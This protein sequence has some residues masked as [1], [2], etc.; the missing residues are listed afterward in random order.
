MESRMET[1][2]NV[3][4]SE[5]MNTGIANGFHEKVANEYASAD[6]L[7]ETITDEL[8]KSMQEMKENVLEQVNDRLNDMIAEILLE[9][10]TSLTKRDLSSSMD[11]YRDKRQSG[12]KDKLP[13]KEFLPRNSIFTNLFKIKHIRTVYN[14]FMVILILLCLNT[15]WSDIIESGTLMLGTET[16]R[17]A[18]AKFPACLCIWSLMQ[19]STLGVYVP[20]NLWSNQR[21]QFS[22]KSLVQKLWDY[23]W[24]TT[25]IL[26]QVLF[27]FFST[28]AMLNENLGIAS[29]LII[30]LEQ[31][32]L[33][34][35]SYAFIRSVAPRFISYK[36]HSD[37]SQ[38]SGPGFSQYL[39]FLFA[40]TL[41]YRDK[42]PRTDKIRWMMVMKNLVEVV[43]IIFFLALIMERF[44]IPVF[45]IFGTQNIEPKWIIKT[46][47][48]ASVPGILFFISGNY[49]LLHAWLNAWAEMLRFADRLFYEDWWNSTSM[50]M[51]HRTWNVVV[52]DWLYMYIYKDMY[53]I[54]VPHNKPLATFTVFFVS[55]ICHDYVFTFAFR[56]FYPLML[57]VFGGSGFIF[58][59]N[60]SNIIMWLTLC[61]C[62][63]ILVSLYAIEYY[64]RYNCSP[65][66][67][68]YADLLLPRSW[69]CQRQLAL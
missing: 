63:S 50:R 43:L 68:Y 20:F 45:N 12:K 22:P 29:S 23:G 24:L 69:N 15:I 5:E 6:D 58:F 42:Y 41:V 62:N 66:S 47:I 54:V 37:V 35:K 11:I 40:P 3:K 46:M 2:N 48:D 39:Y 13:D 49:L 52:H 25:F 18:F 44:V 31:M 19:I 10:K 38:P 59:S 57:I 17:K 61:I 26:Y 28:R 34:M 51:F 4:T 21:L 9:F 56:F 36:P 14:V 65:Y 1:M 67:D 27:L 33:T 53:E 55:S 60:I 64:A 32:R 8:R 30:L 7:L 16:I